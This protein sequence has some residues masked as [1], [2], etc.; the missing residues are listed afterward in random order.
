ME[1]YATVEEYRLD[2]GDA[3]SPDD[4]VASALSQ[5]SAKLR[6]RAGIPRSR[7]LTEDQLQLARMLVTDA[8]GKALKPAVLDG[9]GDVA[10][11]KQASF[12]ANGFQGSY[13]L[14]NPSG[15]AYFDRDTLKAFLRSLGR[16]QRVGSVMPSYGGLR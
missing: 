6:S 13:T 16:S 5:Q 10:G 2:T 4:R 12:S 8:V 11:A 1:A 9:L 3:T 15:T 14:A 7:S